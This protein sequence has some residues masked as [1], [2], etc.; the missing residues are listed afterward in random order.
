M[1]DSRH[2]EP[3]G[4]GHLVGTAG[5]ARMGGERQAGSGGDCK[6]LGEVFDGVGQLVVDQAERADDIR[7]PTGGQA[8]LADCVGGTQITIRGHDQ[9]SPDA[10]SRPRAPEGVGHDLEDQ[11]ARPDHLREAVEV[12]RRLHPHGAVERGVL[13]HLEDQPAEVIGIANRPVG[14]RIGRLEVVEVDE[15]VR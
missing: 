1:L 4:G 6:R 9:S 2:L 11:L 12:Q 8:R 3:E 15:T 5:L 7:V 10:D 13:D 14:Q